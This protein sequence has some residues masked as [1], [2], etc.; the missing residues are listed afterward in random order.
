MLIIINRKVNYLLINN[1][2]ILIHKFYPKENL[3][4]KNKININLNNKHEVL[5]NI[6]FI[7]IH[8]PNKQFNYKQKT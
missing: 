2:K 7:L 5:L 6:R 3:F 8:Q 4:N 1:I